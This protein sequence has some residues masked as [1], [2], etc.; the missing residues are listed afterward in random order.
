MFELKLIRGEGESVN[1][2]V[3]DDI[4]LN[5][6]KS[7]VTHKWNIEAAMARLIVDGKEI[8]NDKNME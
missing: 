7:L 8:N 3:T 1:F 5:E 4:K 2:A 6:I